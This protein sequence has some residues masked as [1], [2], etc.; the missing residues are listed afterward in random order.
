[1]RDFFI[2]ALNDLIVE[3][4]KLREQGL[5]PECKE[6]VDETDFCSDLDIEEFRISGLCQ[7]CQDEIFDVDAFDLDIPERTDPPRQVDLS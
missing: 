4:R 6:A 3:A 7:D 1:M 2:L 5:C